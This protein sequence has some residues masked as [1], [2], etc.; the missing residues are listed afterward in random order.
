M[1]FTLPTPQADNSWFDSWQTNNLMDSYGDAFTG[2]FSPD[3]YGALSD[4][5]SLNLG[6]PA[7]TFTGK[8]G[9]AWNGFTNKASQ[10]GTS[11]SNSR[12]V[13]SFLNMPGTEQ[14]NAIAGGI[15]A[16][17]GVWNGYNQNKMANKQ[18]NFQKDVWNQQWG[19]SKKQYNTGLEDRQR[20]RVAS[21][22]NAYQSVGS[23]MDKYGLK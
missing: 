5:G 4:W 10:L 13:Q 9:E 7:T 15:T 17:N 20:A 2:G 14:L 21:N 18:F 19:A 1:N 11:I 8:L 12:P 23:Y 22:P 3:S 16:L 6:G